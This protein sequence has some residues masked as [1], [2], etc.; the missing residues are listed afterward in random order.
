MSLIMSCN[1][2]PKAG[3]INKILPHSIKKWCWPHEVA[4]VHGLHHDLCT[5]LMLDERGPRKKIHLQLLKSLF[6]FDNNI[7]LIY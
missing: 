1:G 3:Y 4:C 5:E 2:I 6:F 7:F